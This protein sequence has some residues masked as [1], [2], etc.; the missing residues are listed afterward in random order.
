MVIL[1]LLGMIYFFFH[2]LGVR[3]SNELGSGP[4]RAEK[5]SVIVTIIKSLIIGLINATIILATKD[6]FT[7]IFTKSKEMIK[8]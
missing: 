5:Y 6:H 4:P 8:A 2:F 3:V 1:Q 7:I